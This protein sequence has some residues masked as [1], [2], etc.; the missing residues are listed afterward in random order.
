MTE[1]SPSRSAASNLG[2]RVLMLVVLLA[3]TGYVFRHSLFP[4]GHEPAPSAAEA[5]PL[6]VSAIAAELRPWSRR[7]AAS[8]QLVARDEVVVAAEVSGVRIL[9]RHVEAG[10]QVAQG[11][12]LAELDGTRIAI[13]IAQNA[14]DAA[15]ARAAVAQARALLD[16][17]EAEAANARVLRQ[18][19]AALEARGATSEQALAERDTSARMAAA[20]AEAQR[21]AVQ[22]AEAALERVMGDGADLVW[23]REHLELRAPATGVITEAAAQTGQITSGDGTP[24]FR[25]LRNSEVEM[26]AQVIETALPELFTGQP[27]LVTVAGESRPIRGRIRRIAPSVDTGTRMARV[28][29]GLDAAVLRPGTFATALFETSQRKGIVVPQSALL[30]SPDGPMIQ[31][32]QHGAVVLR[33]VETGA[34]TE[35]GIEIRAG[36]EPGEIV[37][38]HAGAFLRAGSRVATV[39]GPTQAL[40]EF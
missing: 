37:I 23:Q 29:I 26:E 36:L 10:D 31:V 6:Q 22:T 3:G 8:G 20:R 18:R 7:I 4:A 13:Q 25:I 35:G 28:W 32:V 40:G 24:L 34:A 27:V 16:E 5:A 2:R 38:L 12:L 39:I 15:S 11:D 1:Q 33:P 9:R 19:G 14:A 30:Q 21:G 17:A